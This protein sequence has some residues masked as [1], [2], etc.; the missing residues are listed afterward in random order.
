MPVLDL[1]IE[2]AFFFWKWIN[3]CKLFPYEF[4]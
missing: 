2:P 1:M 4:Y 3:P